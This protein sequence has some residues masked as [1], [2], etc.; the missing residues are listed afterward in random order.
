MRTRLKGDKDCELR[1]ARK[2]RFSGFTLLE[3][4]LCMAI[5]GIMLALG[6]GLL[7]PRGSPMEDACWRLSTLLSSARSRAMLTRHKVVLE[8][9]GAS[10]LQ[11]S[12]QGE[13]T[14]LGSLPTG[15]S[16]NIDG[17]PLMA[18][19]KALFVF[20]PLGYT[21]ERVIQLGDATHVWSIYLPSIG[22]PFFLPGRH[23]LEELRKEYP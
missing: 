5:I 9:N 6:I 11:T 4:M 17:K 21:S 13:K 3:L 8:F 22:A 14:A 18:G 23:D 2:R 16:V 1:L 7:S 12:A 10:I 20:S 15:I 19:G